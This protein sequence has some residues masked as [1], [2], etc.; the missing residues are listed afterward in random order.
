[1]NSELERIIWSA[2]AQGKPVHI[3]RIRSYCRTD[4][5]VINAWQKAELLGV[6]ILGK[7]NYSEWRTLV[8]PNPRA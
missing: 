3:G 6:R 7:L 5:E 1:M 2:S 8:G 4:S